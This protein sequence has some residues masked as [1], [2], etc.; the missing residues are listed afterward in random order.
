MQKKHGKQTKKSG[1]GSDPPLVWEKFPRKVVFFSG[2][3][4]LLDSSVLVPISGVPP[5]ERLHPE[6]YKNMVVFGCGAHQRGVI[7]AQSQQTLKL[8]AQHG[9]IHAYSAAGSKN[10]NCGRVLFSFVFFFTSDFAVKKREINDFT[11]KAN[12][13]T[14]KTPTHKNFHI[15]IILRR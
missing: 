14:L 10:Q 8:W 12:N 2:G 7:A 6:D 11:L 15:I 13:S 1:F 4:P 3:R 9:L 5:C